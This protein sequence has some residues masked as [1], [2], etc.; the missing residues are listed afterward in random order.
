[1]DLRSTQPLT[2]MKTRNFPRGKG[3]PACKADLTAICESSVQKMWEPRGLTTIWISMACYKDSLARK[4]DNF[5]AICE[6]TVQKI[7]EPRGL[8]TLWTSTACY[9]DVF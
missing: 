9:M 4:A 7:W 5:T 2:E 1:M 8:T 3:W 6:S